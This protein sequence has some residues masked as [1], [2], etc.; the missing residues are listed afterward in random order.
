MLETRLQFSTKQEK[1]QPNNY[2]IICRKHLKTSIN[3]QNFILN[4]FPVNFTILR[5]TAG[6]LNGG[7]NVRG[8]QRTY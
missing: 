5:L 7:N 2:K 1:P 4:N 8:R 3:Q 6:M